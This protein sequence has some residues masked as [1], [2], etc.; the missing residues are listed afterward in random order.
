M[1]VGC[2]SLLLVLVGPLGLS[3]SGE[4][5]TLLLRLRT[6]DVGHV[7]PAQIVLLVESLREI[8]DAVHLVDGRL[9]RLEH[10]RKQLPAELGF[11]TSGLLPNGGKCHTATE[12]RHPVS[13]H[14]SRRGGYRAVVVVYETVLN[15]L[16]VIQVIGAPTKSGDFRRLEAASC[17]ELIVDFHEDGALIGVALPASVDPLGGGST[18]CHLV[19]DSLRR[20]EV[21]HALLGFARGS[22][23]DVIFLGARLR[24]SSTRTALQQD[25][26]VVCD[27]YAVGLLCFGL[28][29]REFLFSGLR[30]GVEFCAGRSRCIELCGEHAGSV[31]YLGLSRVVDGNHGIATAQSDIG[32]AVVHK[33]VV[34]LGKTAPKHIQDVGLIEGEQ[35]VLQAFL[36]STRSV[37]RAVIADIPSS[38]AAGE[39]RINERLIHSAYTLPTETGKR[40]GY[41]ALLR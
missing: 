3:G 20:S 30:R 40:F 4:R 35:Q 15:G 1:P 26:Y 13:Y 23:I 21:D 16:V 29:L 19:K 9:L 31:A 5:V 32:A 12:L 33:I 7:L 17:S 8:F 6:D 11:G 25:G 41:T 18:V 34:L 2:G 14:I 24:H 28:L 39:Q 37:K 22:F 10:F 38:L 36:Q 27:L